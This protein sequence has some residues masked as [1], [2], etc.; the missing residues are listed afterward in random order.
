VLAYDKWWAGYNAHDW[1][2]MLKPFGDI[3]SESKDDGVDETAPAC[4]QKQDQQQGDGDEK[5]GELEE[6]K[7]AVAGKAEEKETGLE[8]NKA[9]AAEIAEKPLPEEGDA[10]EGAQTPSK[11]DGAESKRVA[12]EEEAGDGWEIVA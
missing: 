3:W 6:D 5:V 9:S 7:A 2:V 12:S 1:E 10:I 8:N 11:D 4:E